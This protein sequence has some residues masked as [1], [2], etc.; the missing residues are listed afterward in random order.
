MIILFSGLSSSAFIKKN[1]QNKKEFFEKFENTY[2]FYEKG[3]KKANSN[4]KF[5]ELFEKVSKK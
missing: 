5:L 3:V 1:V 2:K 4:K